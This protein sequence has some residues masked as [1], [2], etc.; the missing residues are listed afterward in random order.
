M[1][2][3][4]FKEKVNTLYCGRDC[5][6]VFVEVKINNKTFMFPVESIGTDDEADWIIRLQ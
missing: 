3:K 1:T 2:T 4:K 5:D 6:N